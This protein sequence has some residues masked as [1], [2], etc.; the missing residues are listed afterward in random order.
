MHAHDATPLTWFFACPQF[1]E[2]LL[3]NE[4]TSL[5]AQQVKIGHAG[6]QAHGD[7]TFAYTALLWSRLAS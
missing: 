2:P 1:I 4:L 7:L 3:A 6:V 5:G